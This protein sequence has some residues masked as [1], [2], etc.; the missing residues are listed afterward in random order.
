MRR[1][2][3]PAADRAA[4][5]PVK[6]KVDAAKRKKKKPP[7]ASSSYSASGV[8]G[9]KTCAHC[10]G[11]DPK[12][13]AT[14]LLRCGRCKAVNFCSAACQRAHWPTHR[15]SCVAAA[16]KPTAPPAATRDG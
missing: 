10:G 13:P 7:L 4:P 15:G 9:A 2:R 12:P 5:A 16:P 11:A 3:A 14:K 6:L 1:R 8:G